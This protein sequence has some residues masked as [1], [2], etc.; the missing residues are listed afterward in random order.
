MSFWV[1][2]SQQ[3]G[4]ENVFVGVALQIVQNGNSSKFAAQ[5]LIQS[6]GFMCSY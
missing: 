1:F 2:I 6:H 3:L 4:L 5:K